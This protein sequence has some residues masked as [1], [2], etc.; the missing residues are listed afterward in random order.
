MIITAYDPY[1]HKAIKAGVIKERVFYKLDHNMLKFP[2]GWA[3]DKAMMD[4][5]RPE[6]DWVHCSKRGVHYHVTVES[7]F[8]YALEVNRGHGWQYCLP[9]QYWAI[10]DMEGEYGERYSA[11]DTRHVSRIGG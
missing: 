9:L 6:F 11:N 8:K 5:Y 2:Q 3:F 10:Q 4:R 7:F 1:K